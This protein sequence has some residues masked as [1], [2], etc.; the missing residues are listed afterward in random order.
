MLPRRFSR[1]RFKTHCQHTFGDAVFNG[2]TRQVK[3]CRTTGTLVADIDNRNSGQTQLGDATLAGKGIAMDETG[4]G[5]LDPAILDAGVL[6][7][8]AARLGGEVVIAT[9]DTGH[10]EWGHAYANHID[11]TIHVMVL[12]NQG[13]A[14][15][16]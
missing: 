12:P 11:A 3:R 8:Q 4:I 2:L 6:Q 13:T 15:C 7:R 9:T 10:G 14:V 5:R 1:R 16:A